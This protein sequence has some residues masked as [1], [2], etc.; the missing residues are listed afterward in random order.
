MGFLRL[1]TNRHVMGVDVVTLKEAWQVYQ[2]FIKD[3][4]VIFLPEPAGIE[5][6]WRKLTQGSTSATNTW[7]DAY[8]CAFASVRNLRVVSFDGNL[9]GA[10][11]LRLSS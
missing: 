3:E 4:R 8:L 1:V 2:K 7:T 5:E 6:V 10:D 9:T 11:A